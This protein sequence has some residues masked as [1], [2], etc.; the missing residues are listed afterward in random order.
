MAR[1]L[2]DRDTTRR[3]YT[4]LPRAIYSSRYDA[5]YLSQLSDHSSSG[6]Y[7]SWIMD[8]SPIEASWL[9]IT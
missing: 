7:E 8:K 6:F 2:A 5:L 4:M 9:S 3:D 1:S